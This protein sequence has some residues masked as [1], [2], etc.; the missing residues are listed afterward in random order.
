MVAMES[1]DPLR[2]PT[3]QSLL[4]LC[5]Y[6]GLSVWLSSPTLDGAVAYLKQEVQLSALVPAVNAC[7]PSHTGFATMEVVPNACRGAFGCTCN[8]GRTASANTL[9]S[10]GGNSGFRCSIAFNVRRN[11]S[12]VESGKVVGKVVGIV[13]LVVC[14]KIAAPAGVGIVAGDVMWTGLYIDCL[15]RCSTKDDFTPVTSSARNITGGLKFPMEDRLRSK[16]YAVRI[17]LA[18]FPRAS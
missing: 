2:L 18:E 1:F 11:S 5:H 6:S 14:L 9:E 16:S 7:A 13:R 4:S 8:I 17:M 3:I 15:P 12:A 10:V